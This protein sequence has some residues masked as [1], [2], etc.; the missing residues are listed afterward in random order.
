[1]FKKISGPSVEVG[2][3]RTEMGHNQLLQHFTP[4]GMVA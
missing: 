2:L 4:E 1:M 3:E